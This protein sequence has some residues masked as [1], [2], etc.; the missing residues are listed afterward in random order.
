MKKSYLTSRHDLERSE[1]R[2]EVWDVGL[3]F[4]QRRCDGGLG[5]VGVGPRRAVGCDLV[6]SGTRHDCD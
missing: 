5:L 4:I 1:S 2:L 3:E 6:E